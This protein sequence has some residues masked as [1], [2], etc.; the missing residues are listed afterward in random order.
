MT[1]SVPPSPAGGSSPEKQAL[2]EA[3]NDVLKA[4][5]DRR[6]ED[7]AAPPPPRE[8][9]ISPVLATGL[10]TL[11]ALVVSIAVTRPPWLGF[12]ETY[13]EAPVVQD[14][15]LRLAIYQAR[16]RVE[17]YRRVHGALPATLP[18]AGVND[19]ALRMTVVSGAQYVIEGGSDSARLALRSD[20]PVRPFLGDAF[21]V[22]VDGRT[23]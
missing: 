8:R 16:Q 7:A 20:E 22:V 5:A 2:L 21:E 10:L 11:V 15:S 13:V 9:L 17:Q 12:A 19:P 6:A 18:I 3:F 14:A 1:S 23:P 4:D